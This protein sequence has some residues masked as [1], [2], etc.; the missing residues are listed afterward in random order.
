[1]HVKELQIRCQAIEVAFYAKVFQ[2]IPVENLK[3]VSVDEARWW[4]SSLKVSAGVAFE[5]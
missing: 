3:Q 1:M 5:C 2:A 4:I